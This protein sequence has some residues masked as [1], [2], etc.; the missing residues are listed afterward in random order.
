[1]AIAATDEMAGAPGGA[2]LGNETQELESN[3]YA[4]LK[5]LVKDAGT[6]RKE[7]RALRRQDGCEH[8]LAGAE[9][10]RS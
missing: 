5:R 1:M 6:L 7:P 3:E 8:R 2:P 10:P 9:C 4:H